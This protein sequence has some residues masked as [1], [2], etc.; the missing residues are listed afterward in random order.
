MANTNNIDFN[1][2]TSDLQTFLSSLAPFTGF[3]FAG[4]N[5][6]ML[7]TLLAFNT[8]RN[9][10]YLNM[11]FS[12][13]YLDSAE[14]YSSVTSRAKELG[15]TPRSATASKAVVNLTFNVTDSIQS[16]NLPA[17]YSFSG[18]SNNTTYIFQTTENIV[19]S[20]TGSGFLA[21]NVTIVEGF[22]ITETFYANSSTSTSIFPLSNPLIDTSTI[23]V[24]V[25]IS[26]TNTTQY[27]FTPATNISNVTS[28]S[29]VYFIEPIYNNQYGIQFGDG[30]LGAAI[31]NTSV[32][33]VS[34]FVCTGTSPNNIGSFQA[35]QTAG[36]N[37]TCVVQT[38]QSSV[39]GTLPET[40]NSIKFNAP[41]VRR[42]Q[43]RAIVADDFRALLLSNYPQILDCYA[44]YLSPP[45]SGTAYICIQF[46]TGVVLSNTL[47]SEIITFIQ[48]KTL[49]VISVVIT[50]PQYINII[51]TVDV[52]YTPTQTNLTVAGLSSSISNNILNFANTNINTFNS[53]FWGSSLEASV[54]LVDAS[55][56]SC[57][58]TTVMQIQNTI[59]LNQ[60]TTITN[61][62]GNPITQNSTTDILFPNVYTSNFYYQGIL[63]YIKDDSNGNLSVYSTTN[64]L[65]S[66]N[67]GT[68]N[69][70]TGIVTISNVIIQGVTGST[71]NVYANPLS[72]NISGTN[73]NILTLATNQININL[74]PVQG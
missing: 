48:T 73:S 58:I 47:Q 55:I 34:Y 20:N 2:Y 23:S 61:T 53:N 74:I 33:S 35:K 52:Y 11:G 28:T 17:G 15:Y 40:I 21:S 65:I 16:F 70:A 45:Q 57:D 22:P 72:R 43:D 12:E 13:M 64:T 10:Y 3:N 66:P 60:L 44:Y 36:N 29:N 68:A 42:A 14:L 38:Q 9:A 18:T 59:N 32:I 26:N 62:F 46:Q 7:I 31:Q 54:A 56:I 19:V 50:S 1:S 37:Y 63:C 69:Y 6:N 5:F 25:Q 71:L 8:M 4:T 30:I 51:P 27:T 49:S 67:I 39:G 41:K 24:N